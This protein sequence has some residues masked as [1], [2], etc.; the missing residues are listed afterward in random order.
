[1]RLAN[2]LGYSTFAPLSSSLHHKIGKHAKVNEAKNAS[3]EVSFKV[4]CVEGTLGLNYELARY[5]YISLGCTAD[6][7][8][9]GLLNHCFPLSQAA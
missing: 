9:E 4:Y 5:P 1:V 7:V 2:T 8:A 6:I 3:I